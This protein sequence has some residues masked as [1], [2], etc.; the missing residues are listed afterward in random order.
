MKINGHVKKMGVIIVSLLAGGAII[1]GIIQVQ[2]AHPTKKNAVIRAKEE[3]DT[4]VKKVGTNLDLPKGESPTVA[5]VTDVNQL[6]GQVFF[7][8]AQN[9]DKVMIYTQ[10]RKAILYRPSTNKIIEVGPISVLNS[11]VPHPTMASSIEALTPIASVTPPGKSFI[12]SRYSD[13]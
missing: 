10:A 3:Y 12:P 1:Y 7:K 6:K 2:L 11:P 13:R 9:G 4:L 8:N 5:T